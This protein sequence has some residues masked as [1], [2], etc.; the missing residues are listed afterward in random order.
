MT[1]LLFS[2]MAFGTVE[3]WSYLIMELIICA[4]ALFFYF[5]SGQKAVYQVPGMLSLLLV[6]TFILFQIIPLP[7]NFIKFLSPAAYDIYHHSSG[8]IGPIGWIPLSIHPRATLMEFFRFSAYTLFYVIAIQLLSDRLLLKKTIAAVAWFASLL[9]ILVIFEFITGIPGHTTP[10]EKILWIRELSHGGTPAGPYVNRN[11]YA[12]LM[13]MIFPLALSLF[14]AYR[15]AI[16]KI[17]LKKRI[18]DF[19]NQKQVHYHFLYGTAAVII[20]TSIFLSISRGGIISLTLSMGIFALLLLL[21]TQKKKPGFLIALIIALVLLFTGTRGWDAI[22]KRFENIRNQSGEIVL[23]TDRFVMWNDSKEIIK[24]FPFFGTGAG[25]Y[26]NIYPGYRTLPGNDIL[27]HAH[28]DYIEF[29]CTGGIIL[30][31][32][33]IFCLFSIFLFAA[34]A[35]GIRREKFSICLF[36]GCITSVSAILIHSFVDFNMQIGANGLYFFFVLALAVSAANT[37]MRSGL[38]ATCLQKSK[39]GPYVTGIFALA[40][41]VGIFYTFGGA[42]IANYLFSDYRNI[43]PM[44]DSSK[45]DPYRLFQAAKSAAAFDRLNPEYRQSAARAAAML[46]ENATAYTYYADS[47]RLDPANSRNIRDAGYFVYRQGDIALADKLFRNSVQYDKNNMAAYLKYAA[48]LFEE[49][50]VEKG[51]KI[52][53]S[54]MTINPQATDT[55]LSLMVLYQINE[56]QMHLALPDRVEPHLAL[57]DFFDS[58]GERQKAETSYLKALEYLPLEKK[59]NK[60]HFTRIHRFYKKNQADE[61]AL[62]IIQQAIRHFPDDYE[63]HNIAGDIYKKLGIGYRAAEEYRKARIIKNK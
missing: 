27:D 24:D 56:D 26:E 2:P 13:E 28:N 23:Q 39:T 34:R 51:L 52:L 3:T 37:R 43:P 41:C 58:L 16:A 48:M 46:G 32:L 55:C 15:P 31:A 9:S 29:L 21:K 4:S 47:V 14:L 30:T 12:G 6:N 50:Q 42:L 8:L 7:G 5:S 11:H 49:N 25:T 45:T 61:K 63:L 17:S 57:G 38:P 59:L 40:L 33:M 36:I 1:A 19:L 62:H 20:A 54:A 10:N 44:P 18:A 60:H 35:Y 22:F 53:K